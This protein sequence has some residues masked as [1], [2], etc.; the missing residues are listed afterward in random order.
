MYIYTHEYNV[1]SSKKSV[2]LFLWT[3]NTS[4]F[5]TNHHHSSHSS[6]TACGVL[7]QT[8]PKKKGT[9]R[10][11]KLRQQA[12]TPSA[13]KP[14]SLRLLWLS[15]I[16][17]SWCSDSRVPGFGA[18]RCRS[19][20]SSSEPS[21][22]A[23]T[24]NSKGSPTKPEIWSCNP[25][26]VRKWAEKYFCGSKK[27]Q[28]YM[29]KNKKKSWLQIRNRFPSW[30]NGEKK[31]C[32]KTLKPPTSYGHHSGPWQR[33]HPQNLGHSCGSWCWN[34]A[35]DALTGSLDVSKNIP[36]LGRYL[37]SWKMKSWWSRK[38]LLPGYL[39][40][41][42]PAAAQPGSRRSMGWFF[43]D[44]PGATERFVPIVS[45][46]FLPSVPSYH[47]NTAVVLESQD[48][49]RQEA[50]GDLWWSVFFSK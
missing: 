25:E 45:H 18:T 11:K 50:Q 48:A 19:I 36:D 46:G 23:G 20:C 12:A 8:P 26:N 15:S 31:R 44:H 35:E 28:I 2:A 49:A 24:S 3:E 42:I 30:W 21:S 5:K 29:E 47:K 38:R 37:R 4:K 9:K 43:H 33:R 39:I 32:L 7:F 17:A 13:S 41:C 14:W 40:I 1:K 34:A 22:E 27:M 16:R 6:I 10:H